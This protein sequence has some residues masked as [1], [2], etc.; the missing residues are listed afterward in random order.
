MTT[1]LTVRPVVDDETKLQYAGMYVLKKM[2]LKPAEGGMVMPVVLA[3]EYEPLTEVL[4]DLALRDLVVINSKKDRWDITKKGLAY[5]GE[6]IDEASELV[7]EFEDDDLPDVVVELRRRNLDPF[8]AR[9][10][11]GWY[12]G[13][14][15]DLVVFQERRGVKP[16]E[17]MWAYYLVS[18]EF[19][20][21]LA[22]DLE[23]EPS[24]KNG[25]ADR[26]RDEA[27]DRRRDDDDDDDD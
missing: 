7:E 26:R 23:G 9:F 24:G 19:Y 17:R 15:D 13:E 16:I 3:S 8:R 4:H 6:L 1:E 27:A 25:H 11:W 10:L 2:D 5:I 18:D 14:F 12:E 21:H 22:L 20:K